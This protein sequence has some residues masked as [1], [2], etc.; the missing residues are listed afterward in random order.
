MTFWYHC[1]SVLKY[2]MIQVVIYQL[3]KKMVQYMYRHGIGL[4]LH[5]WVMNALAVLEQ[6]NR[7]EGHENLRTFCCCVFKKSIDQYLV[8]EMCYKY[9]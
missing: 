2:K 4:R 1:K 3:L 6:S 7:S 5:E 8:K 9:C